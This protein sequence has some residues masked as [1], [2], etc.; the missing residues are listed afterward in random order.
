MRFAHRGLVQHAPENTL[1]AFQ[2]AVDMGCEGIELDVRVSKDGV[3]IVVHDTTFTRMTDGRLTN[4]ICN[5]TAEE[6]CSVK[7]PYAG[8]LLPFDPPAPYSEG[9]GSARTYTEAQM[10]Y[11]RKTDPRTTK[12]STFEEFDRWFTGITADIT[13][14]IEL[15]APGSF[16]AI[17]S[18]LKKSA[19]CGRY[20]VF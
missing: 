2:A 5:M 18:I 6:I 10:D 14:E 17:Y 15:C 3:A 20:I 13:I 12:L 19:N 4:E 8:H 7:L 16:R 9:E 1:E 11:F